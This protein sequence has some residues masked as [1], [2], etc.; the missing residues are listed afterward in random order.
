[1]LTV[2]QAIVKGFHKN[3]SHFVEF[4]LELYY[5]SEQWETNV[6]YSAIRS[7][8]R[9]TKKLFPSIPL[10]KLG[11]EE[12]CK[13]DLRMLDHYFTTVMK[14]KNVRE[15]LTLLSTLHIDSILAIDAPS[16]LTLLNESAK[17]PLLSMSEV[18]R[19]LIGQM[20]VALSSL[21]GEGSSTGVDRLGEFDGA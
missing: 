10:A 4:E 8:H 6:T 7:F 15:N 19:A 16:Q 13:K 14:Y 1:M 18:N 11:T 9:A 12:A 20:L 17:L 2:S 5:G 21:W 3:K